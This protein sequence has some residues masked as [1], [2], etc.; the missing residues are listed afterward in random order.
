[1]QERVSGCQRGNKTMMHSR[2][3]LQ[4]DLQAT[5]Y[6]THSH[7]VPSS[8][9]WP[10]EQPIKVHAP[11]YATAPN[12]SQIELGTWEDEGGYC[13]SDESPCPITE[14]H[15]LA[16]HYLATGQVPE[17][18]VAEDNAPAKFYIVSFLLLVVMWLC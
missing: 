9:V 13:P 2:Y 6:R 10:T 7:F 15:S 1:M 18:T 12:L 4:A 16:M 14:P 17:A 3:T 8:E 5:R 11:Q